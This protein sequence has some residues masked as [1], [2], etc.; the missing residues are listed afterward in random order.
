MDIDTVIREL[1]RK[2]V[3]E[4]LAS[5]PQEPE[6]IKVEEAVAILDCDASVVYGMIKD[7]ETNGFPAVVLGPRNFRIDKRRL[8]HW[9]HSGGLAGL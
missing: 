1:V 5:T 9:I 7:R 3:D 6:L 2:E 8:N 4:R